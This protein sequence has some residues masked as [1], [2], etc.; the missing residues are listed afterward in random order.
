MQYIACSDSINGEHFI[1]FIIY[2]H[3]YLYGVSVVVLSVAL[4]SL[5]KIEPKKQVMICICKQTQRALERS[6]EKY[7]FLLA[8]LLS[9]WTM[10]MIISSRPLTTDH[11][12]LTATN[13]YRLYQGRRVRS[14]GGHRHKVVKS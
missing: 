1:I 7:Y 4:I 14:G 8:L 13:R 6:E 5:S 9:V 2:Y 3:Y 11:W 12:P 10:M